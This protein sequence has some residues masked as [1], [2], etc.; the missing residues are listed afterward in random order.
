MTKGGNL[1]STLIVT[2]DD[3]KVNGGRWRLQSGAA[4]RVRGFNSSSI[5]D[6]KITG[7]DALPIHVLAETDA[8]VNGGQ[9]LLK[10]GQPIQVTDV[11]GSARGV[12]QGKAIPVWPVDNDGNYDPTF[13]GYSGKVLGTQAANLLA[14]WQLAEASGVVAV[15]SSPNGRNGL[16]TSDV[17]TWPPQ[18]G[19]GDGNTAP[20]FDSVN[21]FVNVF[22]ASLQAAFDGS[23]GSINI[24]AKVFNLGVWT[25]GVVR[26]FW[27]F[28]DFGVNQNYLNKQAAADTVR[29]IYD[30]GGT[31]DFNDETPITF[32]DWFSIGVTWSLSTGGTGELRYYVQGLPVAMDVG[33]GV[34]GGLLTA[35][36][37]T[38]G[39]QTT[40]G[41]NKWHGNLAHCPLWDIPLT[42]AE[43]L[44]IG[45][46]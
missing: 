44:N 12:I 28:S 30:A 19:I 31:L 32:T 11:I 18:D 3:L 7:G 9:W 13:A 45:V 29:W 22:S 10:G 4:I 24:W 26:D 41:A 1:K 14:Y 5:G 17:S 20:F 34:W 2:T 42:P 6:R 25:D 8:R 15:D 37:A 43:M 40:G 21:D 38:I 16:Y 39:V 35:N 36:R 33:L 46:L 23:E 27:N